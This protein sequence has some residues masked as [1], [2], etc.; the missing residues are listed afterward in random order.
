MSDFAALERKVELLAK[1][2][3]GTAG[4]RRLNAVAAE[5]KKDVDEAVKADLGDQS[6]SGWRRSKPINL[7]GRYDLIDDHSFRVTPNVSGPMVVL[8]EGRNRGKSGPVQRRNKRGRLMRA[9]RWNGHTQP[10][11][12]W[13]EATALMQR[14]VAERVDRQVV[15]AI[16]NYF[17]G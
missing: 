15:K 13:S 14:R 9:K 7:K 1:E 16:S 4:K 10:K 17:R 8:E 5:T 11:H 3:S 2:F 6:M 12:T